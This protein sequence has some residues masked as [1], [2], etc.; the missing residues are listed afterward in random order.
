MFYL[1]A[2]QNKKEDKSICIEKFIILSLKKMPP[3]GDF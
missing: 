3:V 2:F 1:M